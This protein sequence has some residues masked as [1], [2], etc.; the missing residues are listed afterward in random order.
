MQILQS[1]LLGIP[2]GALYGLMG[3]GIAL[4]FRSTGVMNFSQGNGGMVGAFTAFSVYLFSGNY[5]LAVA[6]GILTGAAIGITIDELLMKRSRKLTHASMLIVTLGVLMILEGSAFLIWGTTPQIFPRLVT[7]PAM[8]WERGDDIL[9]MAANDVAITGVALAVSLVL[10]VTL[11]FTKF[12]VATRARSQ[13]ELGA[14]A[15]GISI[16][17]VDATV[18]AV[19]VGLS[20]LVGVLVAPRTSVT[21]TMLVNYQLYG[22]TAAVLGGFT[23]F[24]GPIVGGL[25]LGVAE[26]L[27]VLGLDSAFIAMDLRGVSA[28]D[29]QLSI[30]FGIIIIV[31]V[32]RPS[33]L[34]AARFQGKV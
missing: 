27:I 7:A 13:D 33:G 9:V 22:L 3:L 31:L 11:K 32:V 8:I 14:R 6:A 10:A 12:G 29:Y 18:W 16:R 23:S 1:I 34:F 4:I 15:V 20:A 5:L 26:K 19:G 17:A 25:I 30:I 24:F 28:A 21:P 2:S